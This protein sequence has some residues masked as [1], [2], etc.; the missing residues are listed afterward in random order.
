M[1]LLIGKKYKNY[2]FNACFKKT[3]CFYLSIRNP[4]LWF[5]IDFLWHKQQIVILFLDSSYGIPTCI[6][7]TRM[8]STSYMK[9][10]SFWVLDLPLWNSNSN[11]NLKG[12]LRTY[13]RI[14]CISKKLFQCTIFTSFEHILYF[15]KVSRCF[16]NALY[17]IE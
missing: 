14:Y 17:W 10:R 13:K 6:M 2:N 3:I 16:H 8:L 9:K 7:V 5:Y 12:K 4:L 15:C 11:S 1:Y